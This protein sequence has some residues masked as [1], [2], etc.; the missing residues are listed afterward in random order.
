MSNTRVVFQ[1]VG[2]CLY[3]YLPT[4]GYYA[5]I[6]TNGKEIRRSLETTDRE[7]AKEH[8]AQFQ[9]EQR[10]IDRSHGEITLAELCD[11]YL[12]TAQHQKPKTIERKTLIVDRIK[13]D[14]PGGANIRVS[15]VK[16]S[17]VQLWLAQ[18]KFG[19]PAR[20]LHLASIKA[21]FDMALDDR[22]ITRSPAVK[23]KKTK[24]DKPIR[25]T[26]SFDEFKAIV[27]SIREQ[28]FSD[29]AEESADFVEFLGLAGLGTAEAAALT[30]GDI[31]WKANTITTFRHK[32]KTGF[33]I[34]IYP[35]VRPLLEQRLATSNGA[36]HENVFSVKNAKKAI[37]AACRRLKLP[38]YLHRSFRRMFITRAIELGVDVKV[39]A[40]WQ[41]HRDGGQLILSTYSHV[42]P[43]HSQR[44]ARLMT[45]GEP[46]NVI[47]MPK[48]GA[49]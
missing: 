32:T 33:Q 5:R 44:M 35:Q 10:D 16:P 30:W 24:P 17:D 31:N 7:I 11:H 4:G 14:W 8:L 39:I 41:G 45:D 37:A 15:K 25:K 13:S 21:I 47:A 48:V 22:I 27:A 1:K 36:S 9:K 19:P 12:R 26:P 18:Y 40:E 34:P 20:N 2:E 28:Q 38:A 3:R 23:I 29:T 43:V 42:R 6:K 49:K 46:A